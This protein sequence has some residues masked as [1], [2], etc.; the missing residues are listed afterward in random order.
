MGAGHDYGQAENSKSFSKAKAHECCFKG[1]Y[2]PTAEMSL[3]IDELIVALLALPR[4]TLSFIGFISVIAIWM[5][6][7]FSQKTVNQ[8]ATILTT[9]GIFATFVGIALGLSGFDTANIQESVPS[10]LAGLKTAFWASVCGVGWAITINIRD[11]L[12]GVPVRIGANKEADDITAA[13]LVHHL[14]AINNALVG[15]DDGSLITQLKLS[16][17][18]TNDKLEALKSAQLEALN[19]LS[20]MSSKVLIE[21]LQDVIRDFNQKITEQFGE[22]FKELNAAVGRLLVWQENY[23][24]TV[25]RVQASFDETSAKMTVATANFAELVEKSG[26]FVTTAERLGTILAAV[27]EEKKQFTETSAQLGQLLQAASGSLP[28]VE[29]KI[30]QLS[31]HLTKAVA[32][33]ANAMRLAIEAAQT[34]VTASNEE[35]TKQ[36]TQAMTENSIALKASMASAHQQMVTT[37]AE[38]TKQSEELIRK[39]KEQIT[40]LDA[41]LTEELS[42]SLS[43]LGRQLA[44][45][46]EKFVSDYQPLTDSLRNLVQSV[47]V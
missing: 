20:E 3:L 42:K 19:K 45:L 13:D 25:E 26:V 30:L 37:G 38:H 31:D 18:E 6:L 33:N 39:T 24:D 35:L 23:K 10:L 46:S 32:A 41:A 17:Q 2:M 9:L 47:K 16:R 28:A 5:H 8:G 22:N 21:A 36:L 34:Q 11:F 40:A 7:R 4:E 43:S 14:K 12:F 29:Q 1:E 44:A 27:N 15:S